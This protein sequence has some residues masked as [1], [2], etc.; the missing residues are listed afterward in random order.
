MEKFT[1]GCVCGQVRIVA[2][3][4][5]YRV[6]V[7]HCL[8]CRKHHGALFYASAVFPEDAVVIE[9]ETHDYKGRHFCPCCGSSVF[10]R[11]SDETEV[12]LGALDSP[13]Q[14]MPT[15]ELWTVR[16]EKWLPPFPHTTC[17][18]HDR[19]GTGRTE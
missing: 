12:L 18:K 2:T 14:L 15:Y 10:A 9:G 1:G 8:D 17:Y 16:R 6:G 7:C 4:R 13:D 3:G 19:D 5:P 11:S